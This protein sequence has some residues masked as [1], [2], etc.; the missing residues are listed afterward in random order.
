MV[1]ELSLFWLFEF[2]HS[3]I[4]WH[5]MYVCLSVCLSVCLCVCVCLYVCM[6]VCMYVRTYVCMSQYL[7]NMEVSYTPNHPKSSKP[8]MPGRPHCRTTS[9]KKPSRSRTWGENMDVMGDF[10]GFTGDFHCEICGFQ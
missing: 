4:S 8:R 7:P 1:H 9:E 5:N 10:M 6:Y 3:P 2:L